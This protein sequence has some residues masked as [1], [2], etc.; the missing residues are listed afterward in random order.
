MGKSDAQTPIVKP[1]CA[2]I[3]QCMYIRR[4]EKMSKVSRLN[5]VKVEASLLTVK[6]NWKLI[7]DELE[8]KGIG[9]KDHPFDNVLMGRMMSAYCYLDFLLQKEYDIF[10]MRNLP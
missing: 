1:R 3:N 2:I 4:G 6:R 9:R 5:L 10:Q 7:E 8:R